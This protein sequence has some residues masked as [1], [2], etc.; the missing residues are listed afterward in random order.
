MAQNL[1]MCPSFWKFCR[2][3]KITSPDMTPAH[4]TDTVI[5]SMPVYA[6]GANW[7]VAI[8]VSTLYVSLPSKNTTAT[9]KCSSWRTT[10]NGHHQRR[11]VGCRSSHTSKANPP[12]HAKMTELGSCKLGRDRPEH[13]SARAPASL[14]GRSSC[15]SRIKKIIKIL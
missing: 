9:S 3:S 4:C 11:A 12:P 13:D 2:P 15:R 6:A 8:D 10:R 14:T 7:Q 1:T 5:H